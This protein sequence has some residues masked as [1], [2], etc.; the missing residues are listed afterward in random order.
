MVYEATL[1]AP[2][3]TPEQVERMAQ[4]LSSEVSLNLRHEDYKELARYVLSLLLPCAMAIEE[5]LSLPDVKEYPHIKRI[6]LDA[7][8]K[9]KEAGL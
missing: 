1:T 9:L 4:V 7:E 2:S 6:F 3:P 8:A 5:G